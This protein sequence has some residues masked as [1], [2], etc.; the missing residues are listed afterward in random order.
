MES[1][2]KSDSGCMY[3]LKMSLC[4]HFSWE[5][6]R[7]PRDV[8]EYCMSSLAAVPAVMWTT[9]VFQKTFQNMQTLSF[10]VYTTVNIL[11]GW[12]SVWQALQWGVVHYSY[13]SMMY[14]PYRPLRAGLTRLRSAHGDPPNSRSMGPRAESFSVFSVSMAPI[15]SIVLPWLSLLTFMASLSTSDA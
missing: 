11:A 12:P 14:L 5:P 7:K 2:Y 1:I 15:C 3:L 8:S 10:S 9:T 6:F 13:Q 4:A